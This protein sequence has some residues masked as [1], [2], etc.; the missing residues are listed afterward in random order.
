MPRKRRE[1]VYEF[2]R[3]KILGAARQSMAE[4]GAAN[5]SLREI[6]RSLDLSAPA[7]Y[8][9]F[10]SLDDLITALVLD[11]FTAMADAL[12]AARDRA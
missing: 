10:A 12:E 5:L 2:T 4:R 3:T 6:A 9:Y 8:H 7:L 11:A 1:D